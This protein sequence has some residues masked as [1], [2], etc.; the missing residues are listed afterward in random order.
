MKP[1]LRS[2]LPYDY[3]PAGLVLIVVFAALALASLL[4]V[5]PFVAFIPG[6]LAAAL[7]VVEI[8]RIMRRRCPCCQK[9][10]LRL[11][12]TGAIVYDDF[13]EERVFWGMCSSCGKCSIRRGSVFTS[14]ASYPDAEPGA[15]PKLQKAKKTMERR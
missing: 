6:L 15:V 14:W 12:G 3:S 5:S 11:L 4:F 8:D 10:L 1:I 9:R 7:T 2:N 13:R